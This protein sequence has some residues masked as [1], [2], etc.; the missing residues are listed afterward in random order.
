MAESLPQYDVAIVGGGLAGLAASIE[1]ARQGFR[2]VL[3]EK[4][5]YPFHRVCGEY[6]SEDSR[7]FLERLGVPVS[8]LELP[9]IR[10]LQV[11][12]PDGELLQTSLDSGGFGISR[13]MLD[14][15]L[16]IQAR[17]EGVD[18]RE[19]VKVQDIFPASDSSRIIANE[20]SL[21]ARLVIGSYGKRSNLDIRWKRGFAMEKAGRLQQFVAVKYHIRYPHDSSTIALHNFRD[22]YCGI[23]AVENGVSC[24]C[25]LT[26]AAN[27]AASGNSIPVMEASVLAR[28]PHL[29]R[30]FRE[31]ER[32]WTEPLSIS[33]VSF[34]R[35]SL[36]ENHVL[37]V[38]DAAGMITPLCG[39]GMSMAL[40]GSKILSEEAGRFLRGSQSREALEK[41]YQQL[42]KDHF[43]R[44]LLAGRL[45]QGWFGDPRLTSW[46]VRA[47]RT[48]PGFTRYLVRQTHGNPF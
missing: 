39:N 3:L 15:L 27:L 2:V 43:G 14:N 38:G 28:N 47:G 42:W 10:K 4:K 20:L 11:S 23:S 41:N 48:F 9:S 13:Y 46:L 32:V 35:K 29:E 5:R 1:L 21:E 45:I 30:I 22:G 33:Q 17:A 8:R 7:P 6:I 26:T 25:Y 12:A 37:M 16:A 19:G 34:S 40:Q 44:R 18:L 31:A 36:I 24:L